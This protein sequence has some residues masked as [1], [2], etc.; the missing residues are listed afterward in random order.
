MQLAGGAGVATIAGCRL[1][2]TGHAD[3][4]GIEGDAR[5]SLA[6]AQIMSTSS[7]AEPGSPFKVKFAPHFGLFVDSAGT[8]ARAQIAFAAA[9]GFRAWEDN[10]L[11][12]RN[13]RTR[14][15]IAEALQKNGVEM[16]V[17]TIGSSAGYFRPS[18]VTGTREDT[19]E[20][21]AEIES[22]IELAKLV[23][24]KWVM[25]NPG[26]ADISMDRYHQL[27]HVIDALR[28][29][30]QLMDEHGI[31]L[32]L[33]PTN[34]VGRDRR[35]IDTMATGYL[36]CRAVAHPN[37]KLLF[38]IYQQQVMRGNIVNEIDA[39]WSEIAYFQIGDHP[40]RAEPMTGEINYVN[41]LR[42]VRQKGYN[43]IVGMEHVAR[44]GSAEGE[45]AMI[46]TYRALDA[47]L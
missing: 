22:H 43:G 1:D 14:M 40:G 31:V 42:H 30:A 17:F 39:C 21:L 13:E 32:A 4:S 29:A 35:I 16:G 12:M 46:S 7:S 25:V 2:R 19:A 15:Q 5:G 28:L 11:T 38:D 36:V 44:S 37:L 47:A 10:A 27:A 9:E 3:D 33:E 6:P 8:D 26:M 45:R 34:S 41:I 18:I 23:G 20:F 24:A